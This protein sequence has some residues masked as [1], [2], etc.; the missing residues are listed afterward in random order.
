M[1]RADAQSMVTI[2]MQYIVY[3]NHYKALR[4]RTET[5]DLNY[6][7]IRPR[8]IECVRAPVP[9]VDQDSFGRHHCSERFRS[10]CRGHRSSKIH[11]IP[12]PDNMRC[13]TV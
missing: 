1:Q 9:H 2:Y 5:E 4:P 13:A 8:A 10:V 12:D 11:P 6:L 3:D 7:Q